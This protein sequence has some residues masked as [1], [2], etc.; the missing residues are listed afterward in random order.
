MSGSTAH[1][2]P[3]GGSGILVFRGTGALPVFERR[4]LP[5]AGTR[6]DGLSTNLW[7]QVH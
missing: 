2:S 1:I 6:P 4:P 3:G 7:L 5:E